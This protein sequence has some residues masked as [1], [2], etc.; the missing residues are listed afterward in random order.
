VIVVT[1]VTAGRIFSGGFPS[2]HFTH[3]FIDEAGHAVEPEAL[4]AISGNNIYCIFLGKI[5]KSGFFF[6]IKLVRPLL[7]HNNISSLNRQTKSNLLI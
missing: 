2:G 6:F 1:L 4:I 3:V 5:F 7:L